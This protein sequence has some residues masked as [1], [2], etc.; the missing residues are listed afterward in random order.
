MGSGGSCWNRTP[1]HVLEEAFVS[2]SKY[3]TCKVLEPNMRVFRG[4]VGCE[5][6]FINNPQN[7]A[8]GEFSDKRWYT[9]V[10][11]KISRPKYYTACLECYRIF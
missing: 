1:L 2:A 11:S 10:A 8:C 3:I 6:I 4:A 9:T 5:F 7:S